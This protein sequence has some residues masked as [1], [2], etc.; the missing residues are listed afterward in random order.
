MTK[1]KVRFDSSASTQFRRAVDRIGWGPMDSARHVIN[2]I[3]NGTDGWCSPR[4]MTPF[5]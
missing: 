3:L 4:H 2:R 1:V 5:D